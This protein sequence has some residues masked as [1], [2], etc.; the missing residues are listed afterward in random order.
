[1][2]SMDYVDQHVSNFISHGKDK[3]YK[4]DGPQNYHVKG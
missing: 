4:A 1:M 2:N 3:G